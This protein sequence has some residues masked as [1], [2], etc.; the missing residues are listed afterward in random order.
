MDRD[1]HLT[2]IRTVLEELQY[3]LTKEDAATTLADVTVL[4]ADGEEP[5]PDLVGRTTSE[6]FDSATEL[7]TDLRESAPVEAIGE[8]GQSEGDA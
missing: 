1:I 8:P 6:E 3:P 5:F 4:Y 2:E 7:E